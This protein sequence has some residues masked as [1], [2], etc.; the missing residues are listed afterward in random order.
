M[1]T[2][3]LDTWTETERGWGQR[4][5]GCSIHL[6]KEDYKKYVESYWSS[7]PASTPDEYERPDNFVREIVL[8]TKLFNRLKKSESG[9]RIWE[10]D[11]REL[12]VNNEILFKD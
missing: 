6:T 12:K 2:A 11:F 9:I 7:M 10:S 3:F 8:G 5:D 1:K 4:S